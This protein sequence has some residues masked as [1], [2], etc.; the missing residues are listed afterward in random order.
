MIIASLPISIGGMGVRELAA[1]AL[2]IRFGISET[3]AA[4]VALFFIPVVILAS[5]LGLYFYLTGSDSKELMQEASS[6][7]LG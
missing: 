1:V 4:A 3:D 2:F 7:K 5:L 6:G